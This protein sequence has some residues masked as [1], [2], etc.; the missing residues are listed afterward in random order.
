M[1][2]VR[3]FGWAFTIQP[4]SHIFPIKRAQ[5]CG[6]GG[7][8][9]LVYTVVKHARRRLTPSV[10]TLELQMAHLGLQMFPIQSMAHV[11]NV[12][13]SAQVGLILRMYALCLSFAPLLRCSTLS[14]T[15]SPYITH[16]HAWTELGRLVALL[17]ACSHTLALVVTHITESVLYVSI[18]YAAKR[19]K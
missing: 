12:W 7:G 15:A 13:S 2:S 14:A 8:F 5:E 18:Q 1:T 16:Q 3:C 4:R 17:G 6:P 19:Q 10:C 11:I 9:C